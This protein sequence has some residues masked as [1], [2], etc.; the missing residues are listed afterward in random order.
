VQEITKFISCVA[1]PGELD[2][3]IAAGYNEIYVMG[4]DGI[5]KHHKL[6]GVN[7]Y[8]RLKVDKIPNYKAGE[9][10]EDIHFLPD[11]HIPIELF[12]QI[13]EFFKQVMIQKKAVL[14]AMA[15]ICWNKTE[16]Y[17]IIIPDQ[18][19]GAASASYDW[20]SLPEGST[21]VCDIH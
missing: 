3:A 10:T 11:G 15:W 16:G 4:T 1:L 17:H 5:Y 2:E 21:I 9:I 8:I 20:N 12:D 13:H 18:K 6:R 14:E 7:R 19:V